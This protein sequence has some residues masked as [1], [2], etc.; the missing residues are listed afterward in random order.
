MGTFKPKIYR[1][2][3]GTKW[4]EKHKGILSSEDKQDIEIACPPEFGG[5]YG[6]WTPEHLFVSSIEICIMTL[7]FKIN[8]QPTIKREDE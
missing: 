3:T 6:C 7:N 4:T 1:Y 5:H 8:L 2:K